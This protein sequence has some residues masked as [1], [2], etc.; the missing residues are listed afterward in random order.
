MKSQLIK[1]ANL[2]LRE[3]YLFWRNILGLIW[4]PYL[5]LRRILVEGDFSQAFLLLIAPAFSAFVSLSFLLSVKLLFN[6]GGK[7]GLALTY[8][9]LGLG[10]FYLIVFVYLFFWLVYL[11][12]LERKMKKNG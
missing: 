11:V 9:T 6:P 4:H 10:I 12:Q 5:T 2:I 8:L 1:I 3:T 7:V